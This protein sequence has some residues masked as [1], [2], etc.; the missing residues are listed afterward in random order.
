MK[1]ILA[2]V[3]ALVLAGSAQAQLRS[4]TAQG[5]LLPIDGLEAGSA[6]L[7]VFGAPGY[8]TYILPAVGP[9][10][11][12]E[13]VAA[14]SAM[15]S[16]TYLSQFSEATATFAYDLSAVPITSVGPGNIIRNRY[17][18]VAFD[19][20]L[21][22]LSGTSYHLTSTASRAFTR[23]GTT[24]RYFTVSRTDATFPPSPIP[25][26][27]IYTDATPQSILVDLNALIASDTCQCSS[28]TL[29]L[30]GVGPLPV[31]LRAPDSYRAMFM[32]LSYRGSRQAADPVD[33][34]L[35]N[36][37]QP[38]LYDREQTLN[39]AFDGE[40]TWTMRAE[41]Y[42]TPE[43]FAAAKTWIDANVQRISFEQNVAWQISS[44]AITA[45]PEPAALALWAIG[46]LCLLAR[47]RQ[48]RNA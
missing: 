26:G 10:Q 47:R 8:S 18:M 38:V 5:S 24:S 36:P 46:G 23:D 48:I 35:P 22:D 6:Y 34:A 42:A 2:A 17:D 30:A 44:T 29:D 20:T 39:V 43:A 40:F 37:L 15:L 7:E 41:D 25:G 9:G 19:M 21:S 45:V 13:A 31:H 28:T 14:R 3:A 1:E 27:P 11:P 32:G 12:F 4:Y 33:A 16:A